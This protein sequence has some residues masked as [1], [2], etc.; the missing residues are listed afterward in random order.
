MQLK[1]KKVFNPGLD[2]EATSLGGL[3]ASSASMCYMRKVS[4][5]GVREVRVQILAAA[6]LSSGAMGEVSGLPLSFSFL[7]CEWN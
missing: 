1:K 3:T 5:L 7:L 4:N 2:V 6:P